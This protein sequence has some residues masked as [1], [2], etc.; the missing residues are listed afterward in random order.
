MIWIQFPTITKLA[1]SVGIAVWVMTYGFEFSLLIV[2]QFLLFTVNNDLRFSSWI[3]STI[4]IK[5]KEDHMM[6]G[7]RPSRKNIDLGQSY[8]ETIQRVLLVNFFR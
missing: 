3:C 8:F 2:Q 5:F 4:F 1:S 6:I 7:E